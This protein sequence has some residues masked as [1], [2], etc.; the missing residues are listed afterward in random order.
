M[1]HG[2]GGKSKWDV[3]DLVPAPCL[4]GRGP[5][6]CSRPIPHRDSTNVPE[7]ETKGFW[8]WGPQRRL[9]KAWMCPGALRVEGS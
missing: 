7:E 8:G 6:T 1:L 2:V 3:T 5:P 4:V 9:K